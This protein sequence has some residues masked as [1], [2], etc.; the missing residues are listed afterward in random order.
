MAGGFIAL[1]IIVGI[2]L[3]AVKKNKTRT[4]R[5]IVLILSMLSLC[6]LAISIY[7][8]AYVLAIFCLISAVYFF[9]RAFV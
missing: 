3:L 1:V 9:A 5:I 6:I 2:Y 4:D 7:I 8:G